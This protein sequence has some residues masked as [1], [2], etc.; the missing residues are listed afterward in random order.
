[1]PKHLYPGYPSQQDP[2]YTSESKYIPNDLPNEVSSDNIE[3]LPNGAKQSWLSGRADLLPPSALLR[4]AEVLK[5][6]ADKYGAGNWR[7]IPVKDN[8]NHAMTHL[9]RYLQG[10][11]SEDHVANAACRMLFALDLVMIERNKSCTVKK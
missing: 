2:T 5:V 9:L 10:D 6:G 8:I 1:M 3:T 4:L 11:E 7:G